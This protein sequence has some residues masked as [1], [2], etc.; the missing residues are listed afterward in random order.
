[1]TIMNH[2]DLRMIL[3]IAGSALFG[4]IFSL[5]G[6]FYKPKKSKIFIIFMLIKNFLRK[7]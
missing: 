1:M 4:F 7:G 3:F 2:E 5:I 6:L